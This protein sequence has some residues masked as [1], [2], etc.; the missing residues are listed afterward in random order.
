MDGMQ[1]ALYKYNNAFL[2][3]STE[4]RQITERYQ[5]KDKPKKKRKKVRSRH[6]SLGGRLIEN[7]LEL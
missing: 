3:I 4:G 1:P 6:K 7:G 2:S 5:K